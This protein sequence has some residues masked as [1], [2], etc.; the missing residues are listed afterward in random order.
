MK[1]PNCG[2]RGAQEYGVL[3]SLRHNDIKSHRTIRVDAFTSV[4]FHFAADDDEL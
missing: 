1:A 3:D 2:T 4:R